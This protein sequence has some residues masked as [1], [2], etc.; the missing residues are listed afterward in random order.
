MNLR[1]ILMRHAK[2]DWDDPRQSDHAR[3]LNPRGRSSAQSMGD[4]LRS[5]NIAPDVALVSDACRTQETFAR[6]A[7]P[8]TELLLKPGLYLAGAAQMMDVLQCAGRRATVLMLGHNPGIAE[9]AERLVAQPPK[10]PRFF[11]YPTC[12]TLV[13]DFDVSDWSQVSFGRGVPVAFVIPRDVM[14]A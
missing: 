7:L 11:D 2:S 10:H 12:A 14:T 6:L 8:E 3:P 13:V 5:Q 4:W 9:L 1:L